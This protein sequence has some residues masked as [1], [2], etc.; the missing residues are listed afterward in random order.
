M[1]FF[2]R[3]CHIAFIS[4]SLTRVTALRNSPAV[5]LPLDGGLVT[6]P[7]A[8]A[9]CGGDQKD[10]TYRKFTVFQFSVTLRRVIRHY[11]LP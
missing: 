8:D 10:K 7:F 11:C 3:R 4:D 5:T 1:S 2:A 6:Q 9:R